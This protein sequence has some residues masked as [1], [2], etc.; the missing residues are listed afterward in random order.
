MST[1][2]NRNGPMINQVS[3]L[4]CERISFHTHPRCYVTRSIS[5]ERVCHHCGRPMSKE[6]PQFHSLKPELS[7]RFFRIS[8]FEN[9]EYAFFID[10]RFYS[11]QE[12]IHC[13]D[14]IHSHYS[15]GCL[16]VNLVIFS[17]LV[18]LVWFFLQYAGKVGSISANTQAS[19]FMLL[20]FLA[21]V[22]LI[23]ILLTVNNIRLAQR[24]NAPPFPVIGRTPTVEIKENLTAAIT[25]NEEGAYSELI[26]KRQG[27]LNYTVR[28]SSTDGQR[29]ER[30]KKN[31]NIYRVGRHKYHGGFLL[32]R[33]N[34]SI[35]FNRLKTEHTN[36]ISLKKSSISPSFVSFAEANQWKWEVEDKYE[37]IPNETDLASLPIKLIP[38]IVSEVNK[39]RALEIR[40]QVDRTLHL[41]EKEVAPLI[42]E[43]RLYC[44]IT[45]KKVRKTDPPM[46]LE[47]NRSNELDLVWG[48][49][50][51]KQGESDENVFLR[52][53]H[54]LFN[55]PVEPSMKFCGRLKL[56]L[57]GNMSG[58]QGFGFFYPTGNE[59][60]SDE[61]K[62]YAHTEIIIDFDLVLQKA[63]LSRPYSNALKPI[64]TGLIPNHTNINR[65]VSELSRN[66]A[67]IQRIIE[68]PPYTN[69]ANAKVYNR[70]WDIAGRYYLGMFSVDFHML[71]TG[72]ERLEDRDSSQ[73]GIST[74]DINIQATIIDDEESL[75][76]VHIIENEI[77][78][79]IRSLG[80]RAG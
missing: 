37:I 54:V 55:E 21:C 33:S 59:R 78:E 3:S 76:K 38:N 30:Y 20:S 47:R 79:T 66:G 56:L 2:S 28:I 14:C 31:F 22:G 36:V 24:K 71:I 17:L 51:L 8:L 29:Y 11:N 23:S 70:Y 62:V 52:T 45:L 6:V 68:N 13:E 16:L 34:N 32:F 73:I 40:I 77:K 80:T 35:E 72:H 65:L 12:G 39:P 5:V 57:S 19:L 53:F 1:P 63:N 9:A 10:E 61:C 67:Y 74:F 58:L 50:P 15:Y 46:L 26:E 48:N 43:L 4:I 60:P 42:Q 18:F 7:T 75:A 25:L 27:E 69:I 41:S 64:E 49:I 44:P